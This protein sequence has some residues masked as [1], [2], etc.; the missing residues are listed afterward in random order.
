MMKYNL[1]LI[2]DDKNALSLML[3]QIE[4]NSLVLEFGPAN[5]RMTRYLKKK[6]NCAV[7]IVEVDKA[8][9]QDAM[10]YSEDCIIGDIEEFEWIEKWENIHF[11]YILFADVLEHLH[12]PQEVLS[13]TRRILKDEGKTIISVPNVGH[14]SVMINLFN[15]VFNYTPLGLLD[16][17]HIHLFAYNTL[18]EFCHYAGYFPVIE[19][20]T[21]S[22]VGENEIL[23][24]Y[25]DV[26]KDVARVLLK[27]KYGNVYQFIFTLQKEEYIK[28]NPYKT[29]YRIKSIIP[30]NFFKVYVDRGDGWGEDNCIS[31]KTNVTTEMDFEMSLKKSEEIK[32]IRIDPLDVNGVYHIKEI[33]ITDE[34]GTKE[35]KVEEEN[36]N[37]QILN[38]Y[39]YFVNDDPQIIINSINLKGNTILKVSFECLLVDI[40]N[41]IMDFLLQLKN[42]IIE[43]ENTINIMHESNNIRENEIN[44][45]SEEVR[46]KENEIS[47]K[48]KELIDKGN[49]ISLKNEELGKLQ[50]QIILLEDK[51]TEYEEKIKKQDIVITNQ[52]KNIDELCCKI[53]KAKS[54]IG[55]VKL[56]LKKEV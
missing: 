9:A 23:N 7:Y 13:K 38:D 31:Y 40:D 49:E 2:T 45:K 29:D 56:I 41:E 10:K 51:I 24:H 16:N 11:D 30:N 21:Y 4:P 19:D 1:E 37:G 39:I 54:F 35:I 8:A 17:T 43:K 33:N 42:N 44:L 18:K 46:A 20:A 55:A 36:C 25:A 52:K 22:A 47:L 27:K 53:K 14:N 48:T 6:L 28:N 26:N 12:N 32:R 3:G 34:N 50:N 5:G 15:N